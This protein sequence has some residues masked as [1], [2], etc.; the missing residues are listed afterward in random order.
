MWAVQYLQFLQVREGSGD[1][2]IRDSERRIP[3][4]RHDSVK[5]VRDKDDNEEECV[6]QSVPDPEGAGD[7]AN[8]RP[9]EHY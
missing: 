8:F 4:G 5:E 7:P 2:V 3:F 1:W 9:P 6:K